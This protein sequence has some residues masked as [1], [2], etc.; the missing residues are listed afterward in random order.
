MDYKSRLDKL[1]KLLKVENLDGVLI[2]EHSNISYFTGYSNFS[3]DER[4][5]YLLI[6]R[7]NQFVFTDARYSEA[8]IKKVSHFE[9]IEI[10]SQKPLTT[11]LKELSEKLKLT[12]VGIEEENLTISEHKK[13]KKSLKKLMG[14]KTHHIRSVKSSQ[15]IYQIEKACKIGDEAFKFILA[16]VEV[17]ISE[18]ELAFEL[19]SYIR[20]NGGEIS[21]EPI[22]AFGINSSVPHHETGKTVLSEKNGQFMLLDFGVKFEHYCSDMTRTVFFGKPT[23]KQEHIYNVVYKAQRQIAK[24]LQEELNKNGF[25]MASKIDKIAREYIFSKGYPSIPH[26]LGHGIGL[27]VHEFP[28]LSPKS[29]SILESGMVFSI[30][31]GIYIPNFGGVRIEDLFAIEGKKLRQLTNS[32]KE[33]IKI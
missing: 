26:S 3:K 8:I 23:E 14:L 7:N 2:S 29:K 22:I 21:F 17:G 19:E 24:V 9:L 4:E 12:N 11:S 27:E 15:E 20:K 13:I 33:I 16:R 1:K 30:E 32:S 31:P 18:K 28:S 25:A 10:S 5:A 6:T